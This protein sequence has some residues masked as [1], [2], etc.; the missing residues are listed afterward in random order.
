MT[1]QTKQPATAA[2]EA[3]FSKWWATYAIETFEHPSTAVEENEIAWNAW[4]AAAA[5]YRAE[6]ERLKANHICEECGA[7]IEFVNPCNC[8]P[9]WNQALDNLYKQNAALRDALRTADGALE[10]AI[11]HELLHEDVFRAASQARAAI[12]AALDGAREGE[13]R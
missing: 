12:A 3:A 11:D 9:C 13:M 5:H 6:V 2:D 10:E 7:Q 1:D 4:N 8:Q